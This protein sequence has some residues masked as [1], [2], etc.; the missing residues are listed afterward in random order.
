MEINKRELDNYI[1]GHYGEDQ[2]QSPN[3]EPECE[4]EACGWQGDSV[5]LNDGHC[6]ECGSADVVD[7]ETD[8]DTV[9]EPTELTDSEN[10]L[11]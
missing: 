3:D 8:E 10:R 7:Y 1:T 5:E 4:C 11:Q 9:K 6:P 2:F